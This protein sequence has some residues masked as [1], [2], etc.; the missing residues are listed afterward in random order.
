MNWKELLSF[1]F[2]FLLHKFSVDALQ[3][4]LGILDTP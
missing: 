4:F 3:H 1:F 2:F